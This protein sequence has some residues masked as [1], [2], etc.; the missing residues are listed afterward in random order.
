MTKEQG[1]Q[2]DTG[3]YLDTNMCVSS[4]P[5]ASAASTPATHIVASGEV[6]VSKVRVGSGR[7]FERA[8][9]LTTFLLQT[10]LRCSLSER[11][12]TAGVAGD[13]GEDG[14]P[15]VPSRRVQ[16]RRR[17]CHA[18]PKVGGLSYNVILYDLI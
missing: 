6:A 16:M 11:W 17:V 3:T 7:V 5:A 1:T 13:G 18:K 10:S 14:D 12:V 15:A 9:I 4:V 8:H 2:L